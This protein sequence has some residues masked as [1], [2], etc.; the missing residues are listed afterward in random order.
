MRGLGGGLGSGK[1][2]AKGV[3]GGGFC[4]LGGAKGLEEE[5]ER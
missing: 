4:G 1:E 3:D 2:V 5:A